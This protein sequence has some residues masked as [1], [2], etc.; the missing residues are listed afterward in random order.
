MK[1]GSGWTHQSSS[2]ASRSGECM[3][4]VA[5]RSV[6]ARGSCRRRGAP[7]AAGW[8]FVQN[9]HQDCA[10]KTRVEAGVVLQGRADPALLP[11]EAERR[12]GR[13][14]RR[15]AYTRYG[16]RG[17]PH[18]TRAHVAVYQRRAHRLAT[19]PRARRGSAGGAEDDGAV[20]RIRGRARPPG[21]R[22]RTCL[23]ATARGVVER[24]VKSEFALVLD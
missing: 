22:L 13:D 12:P 1:R 16:L 9:R 7:D 6:T 23:G 17:A 21:T 8:R 4:D 19:V 10:Q 11:Y 3:A 24:R 15:Q 18:L 2:T 5:D 14:D 20:P